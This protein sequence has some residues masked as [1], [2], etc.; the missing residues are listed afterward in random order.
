MRLAI[1]V[2]CLASLAHPRLAHAQSITAE[3]TTAAGYSTDDVFAGA[4]QLRRSERQ[5]GVRFRR[6]RLGQ[7]LDD[8]ND[9]LA[10]RIRQERLQIIE[11]Y[12]ADVP[13]GRRAGRPRGRSGRRSASTTAAITYSAC[14]ARHPA[15]RN[16]GVVELRARLGGS[17]PACRS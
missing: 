6:C 12:R 8:D 2:A 17:S 14:S 10:R 16:T 11:A 4:A 5:G 7:Q 1:L 9:V 13:A 15:T 3:V